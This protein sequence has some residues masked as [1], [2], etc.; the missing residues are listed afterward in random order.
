MGV[1]SLNKVKEL[2]R[3]FHLSDDREVDNLAIW[4]W[5]EGMSISGVVEKSL[6]EAEEK[7]LFQQ[8]DRLSKGEPVQYIVGHTWFFGLKLKVN[9]HVLIPR[10]ETEELVEWIIADYVSTTVPLR[11]LDIGT[12][13]GCI[14]IVLKN[15]FK[16]RASVYALDVSKEAL[17]V[18]KENA[19]S[20]S[21]EIEFLEHDFIRDGLTGLPEFDIIVSNP[22]YID[23]SSI[24]EES[25]GGIYHEPATALFPEGDDPDIFYKKVGEILRNHIG[26]GG[27]C[28]LELNEFRS[29]EIR[30]SFK[31]QGWGEG[32]TR[33]DMQGKERMLK[34]IMSGDL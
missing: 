3:P 10:P 8:I 16:S 19:S 30:N 6:S 25:F 31:K 12:G 24:D 34:I 33:K 7:K 29:T 14:A 28:Y 27:A 20:L 18:A 21:V 26:K 2:I 32:E 23:L 9:P 5:E 15:Y 11:I 22:P 13:S 17:E 1:Y 4:V